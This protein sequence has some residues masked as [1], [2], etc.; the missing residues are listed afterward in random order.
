M[1]YGVATANVFDLLGD[2]EGGDDVAPQL[3]TAPAAKK[4]ETPLKPLDAGK[5]AAGKLILLQL[6]IFSSPPALVGCSS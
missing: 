6:C 5:D 3:N 2:S 1:A 4:K